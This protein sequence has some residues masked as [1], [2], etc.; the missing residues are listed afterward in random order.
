MAQ[1]I[2]AAL[3]ESEERVRAFSEAGFEAIFFS[4]KGVCLEQNTTAEKMFGYTS[5]EAIGRKG[6]DWIAAEDREMVMNNMLSDHEGPYEATALRKDGSTFPAEIQARMMH[7]QGR[8]VRVTALRDITERKK[9]EAALIESEERFR[10]LVTD[11]EE[12]V[13]MI[14]EDGTFLLSEGKGLAKLG[15]NPGEVVGHSVFELYKEH[16][17]MLDEMRRAFAGETITSEVD[18]DGN[19]F[20][21]WYTPHR[22][23]DGE[24]IGLLGLSVNITAQK[25]AESRIED[26]QVRLRALASELILSE[27][28]ERRRISANLHDHVGQSLAAVRMSHTR[29]PTC[30][31]HAH[32][33]PSP[34]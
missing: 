34:Q 24:I 20:R 7:Y 16:P 21:S 12:I 13:Y 31:S 28:R 8:A 17:R 3:R 5:A 9:V 1:K 33:A 32:L 6:T 23:Q 2:E 25:Q 26:Y 10:I 18:V 15:L 11:T 30:N 27:D 22:N 4:E 14:A 19:Y 29:F